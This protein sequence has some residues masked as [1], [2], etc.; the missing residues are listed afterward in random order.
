LEPA[1]ISPSTSGCRDV[2]EED[3]NDAQ[4]TDTVPLNAEEDNEGTLDDQQ[5]EPDRN[6]TNAK[7]PCYP[8][9]LGNCTNGKNCSFAHSTPDSGNGARETGI[10]D[11]SNPKNTV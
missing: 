8:F 3:V 9:Q 6:N 5:P 11:H 2:N 1:L 4:D 10:S 7:S